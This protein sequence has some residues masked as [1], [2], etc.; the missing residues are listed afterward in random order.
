LC[1]R[2]SFT[3]EYKAEVV[4]RIVSGQKTAGQLARELDLTESAVRGWVAQA[5]RTQGGDRLG[6]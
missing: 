3:D 6:R 1:G 5:R 4:K 2:R